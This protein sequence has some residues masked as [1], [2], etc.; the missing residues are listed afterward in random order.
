MKK[1]ALTD[2]IEIFHVP[3]GVFSTNTKISL[4]A[5]MTALENKKLNFGPLRQAK[6]MITAMVALK[7]E[8]AKEEKAAILAAL[9]GN[10]H[11][12]N[13]IYE[14]LPKEKE[15]FVVD[16]VFWDEWCQSVN[17]LQDTDFGLKVDRVLSIKNQDLMEPLHQ[18]RMKDLV[19]K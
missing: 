19:Y 2:F 18:F 14:A 12:D 6:P 15:F 3:R 7:T 16:R 4:D 10:K 13:Y 17:W 8:S 5:F 11:L 9:N 1:Q